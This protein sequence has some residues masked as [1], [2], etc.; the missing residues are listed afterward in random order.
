[1]FPLCPA[2]F[3]EPATSGFAGGGVAGSGLTGGETGAMSGSALG[4]VVGL[5]LGVKS[6][7][8]PG[9][10]FGFGAAS[11]GVS[12]GIVPLGFSVVLLVEAPGFVLCGRF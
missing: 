1:L 5:V 2:P 9:V 3:E 12:G 6:G 8:V 11:A 4:T 7:F 10:K